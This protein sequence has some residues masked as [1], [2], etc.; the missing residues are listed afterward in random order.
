MPGINVNIRARR[1]SIVNWEVIQMIVTRMKCIFGSIIINQCYGK[2]WLLSE[3]I[4]Y[5]VRIYTYFSCD[6]AEKDVSKHLD[7]MV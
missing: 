5:L 1:P 2:E 4:V 3:V 6:D 7:A